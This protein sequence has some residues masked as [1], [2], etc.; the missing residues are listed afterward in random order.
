MSAADPAAA[1][2][3]HLLDTHA[4]TL[5]AVLAAA[6]TV[7][8][9]WN[10]LDDGRPATAER[11]QLVDGLRS[12]LA[13]GGVLETLPE[14]LVSA[15]D[16]A[17]YALPATPVPAPP[18]VVLT[19]TGPVL[20]GTVDDGRLV[21]RIDCFE[22]VRQPDGVDAPVAYAH[23]AASPDAALSVSFVAPE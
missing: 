12:E 22:I 13:D 20:R 14:T 17:G 2:R 11:D 8:A 18:Y 23:R 15:V 21:V 4:D 1:A 7:A 10:P 3:A 5:D 9:D 6:D 16:A 19:T